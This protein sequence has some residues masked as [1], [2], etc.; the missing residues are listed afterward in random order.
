MAIAS[1]L[2]AIDAHTAIAAADFLDRRK[3]D[4]AAKLRAHFKPEFLSQ[5]SSYYQSYIEELEK[6][7]AQ[8][9]LFCLRSDPFCLLL[10]AI[11][12]N[13]SSSPTR[14]L[15]K[16][17]GAEGLDAGY[18]LC[19]KNTKQRKI[20]LRWVDCVTGS[21]DQLPV[22]PSC[23][24]LSGSLR[25]QIEV[26]TAEQPTLSLSTDNDGLLLFTKSQPLSINARKTLQ[27]TLVRRIDGTVHRAALGKGWCDEHGIQLPAGQLFGLLSASLQRS[28]LHAYG[29]GISMLIELETLADTGCCR[30][31]MPY[32]DSL[33]LPYRTK[34]LVTKALA[35][36]ISA[37]LWWFSSASEAWGHIGLL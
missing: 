14:C 24:Y 13:A 22:H 17:P 30:V 6:L 3:P 33:N 7:I 31:R 35:K 20:N 8:P 29:S 15:L 32:L 25:R 37:E 21:H 2:I 18:I 1:S 11:T 12:F 28:Y 23:A 34:L 10:H 9:H 4:L 16:D 19:E 27:F 26:L 36:R 5:E